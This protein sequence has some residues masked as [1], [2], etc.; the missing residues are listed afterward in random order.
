[1]GIG[2]SR[3][4]DPIGPY[5]HPFAGTDVPDFLYPGNTAPRNRWCRGDYHGTVVRVDSNGGQTL[6]AHFAFTVT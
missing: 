5:S 4:F 2:V 6:L 1:M 3:G